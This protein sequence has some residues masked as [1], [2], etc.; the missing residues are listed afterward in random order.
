MNAEQYC[1][2]LEHGLDESFEK[3]EMTEGER[4][5]QEDN[6]PKYTSKQADQWFS[7]NNIEVMEWPAQ[8]P[9][10]NPIGH[11]WVHVK[12]QMNTYE[13]PPKRALNC[14]TD[15]PRNGAK[16]LQKHAKIL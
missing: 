7:D 1:K 13:T 3:L 10:L 8:S 12:R 6:N 5:F 14:G 9:D 4:I 2:I 15:W 16:S 11:L